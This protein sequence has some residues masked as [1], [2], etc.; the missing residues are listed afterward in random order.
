MAS[1]N[2]STGPIIQFN[3]RDRVSTLVSL[4]TLPIFSYLT[5]ARGGYIMRINPIASGIFVVP[6]ENELIKVD[7]DGNKCPIPIP[8]AIARNIHKVR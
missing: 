4:N 7:E 1:I 5:L 8:R 2:M 6:L 3:T